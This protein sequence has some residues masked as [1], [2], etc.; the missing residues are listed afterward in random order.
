MAY[1]PLVRIVDRTFE[2][3]VEALNL[4]L[5]ASNLGDYRLNFTQDSFHVPHRGNPEGL[6]HAGISGAS[7]F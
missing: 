1:P 7:G 2:K 3:A 5:D 4:L 6:M